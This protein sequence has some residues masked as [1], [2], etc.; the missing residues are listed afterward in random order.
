MARRIYRYATGK[1]VREKLAAEPRNARGYRI[2]PVPGKPG[3]KLLVAILPKKGPR[4][5][6]TRAVALLRSLRTAKGRQ[7]ARRAQ[8]KRAKR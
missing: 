2:V 4:G 8:V 1:Y 5:G 6:R 7:L 3:R